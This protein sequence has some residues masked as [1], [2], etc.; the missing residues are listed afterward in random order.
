VATTTEKPAENPY[1]DVDVVDPN[2]QYRTLNRAAVASVVLFMLG[3]TGLMFWQLL[4][5]PIAGIMLGYSALRSIQRF[6]DEYTGLPQARFGITACV[7]LLIGGIAWHTYSYATEVPEGYTRVSFSEL[8]PEYGSPQL[9]KR[10]AE[11]HKKPIFIKGYMHPSV[12]GR[13]KVNQFVLVPD[14]GTCCFGGQPKLTDMILVHTTPDA[15]VAYGAR[16]IRLAG[17]F[18]VGDHLEDYGDVKGVLYRL[19]ADYSK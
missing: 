10:V 8:Q 13:N 6:P 11:L 17:E 4:I 9:P 7:L 19:D 16:V 2:L 18:K 5:L 3:L 14:M 15:R 1:R 12:S